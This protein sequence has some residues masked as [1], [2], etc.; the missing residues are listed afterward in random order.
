MTSL[1]IGS[2]PIIVCSGGERTDA[3]VKLAERGKTL[4]FVDACHS[5]NVRP[6]TKAT[7]TDIDRYAG[8]LASAE[9]GVVVFSSSTSTQL[10]IEDDTLK[11]G[12]FTAALLEAFD[13]R[14]AT[15][16]PPFFY[17]TDF[18]AYLRGRVKELTHGAQTPTVT[19]PL[20]RYNNP[21]VFRTVEAP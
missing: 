16:E 19:I 9:S 4:V 1:R 2:I 14:R 15:H 12:D 8:E 10:S 5:G 20:E 11:H 6:G 18:D 17:V 7:P 3:E 21:R 13:T